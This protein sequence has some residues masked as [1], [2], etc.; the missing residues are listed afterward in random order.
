MRLAIRTAQGFARVV[1]ALT[2]GQLAEIERVAHRV[3]G[4]TAKSSGCLDLCGLGVAGLQRQEPVGAS[5]RT[6]GVGQ[7]RDVRA[8]RQLW[9]QRQL[10][11]VQ[12]TPVSRPYELAA[13]TAA[14]PRRDGLKSTLKRHPLS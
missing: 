3:D 13:Q 7:Q 2:D 1:K 5:R 4:P 6:H 11:A 14:P 9:L 10:C 12:L 8:G